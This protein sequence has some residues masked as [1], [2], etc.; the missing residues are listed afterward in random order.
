MTPNSRNL[1]KH[2]FPFLFNLFFVCLFVCL[3][4]WTLIVQLANLPWLGVF[5]LEKSF[6]KKAFYTPGRDLSTT[7]TFFFSDFFSFDIS[8]ICYKLYIRIV[9]FLHE[10]FEAALRCILLDRLLLRLSR[11]LPICFLDHLLLLEQ[12]HS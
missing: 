6:H 2:L 5:F 12:L 1:K 4:S 8:A 7:S 3:L 10:P 11:R 9:S